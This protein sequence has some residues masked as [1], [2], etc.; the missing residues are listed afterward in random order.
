MSGII[1]TNSRGTNIKKSG[2]Q[3]QEF[4]LVERNRAPARLRLEK[5]LS[6][7]KEK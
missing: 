4:V 7:E 6:I 3:K 1:K 5:K 2:L